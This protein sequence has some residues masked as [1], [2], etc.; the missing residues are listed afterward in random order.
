MKNERD[1]K[2]GDRQAGEGDDMGSMGHGSGLSGMGMM[3][4]CCLPMIAIFILLAV[5]VLR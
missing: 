3:L 1:Q 2:A 4:L 5:G